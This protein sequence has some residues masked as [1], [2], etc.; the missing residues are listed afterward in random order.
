MVAR[1]AGV[2]A[3]Q[4]LMPVSAAALLIGLFAAFVY[5]P[6]AVASFEKSKDVEVSIFDRGARQNN[7]EVSSYW[8]K[9]E[10]V[11]GS[12][13]INARLARSKGTILDDVKI[14]RFDLDGHIVERIDAETA[15]FSGVS[16]VLTNA[17]ISRLESGRA[18]GHAR[19]PHQPDPRHSRRR[20]S[21]C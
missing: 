18:Q 20:Y 1:A 4:F 3:W 17:V 8:M 14:I 10:E 12:N 19:C 21:K 7:A 16:W 5:N 9:Q 6:I 2:S 15:V 11:D 13:V